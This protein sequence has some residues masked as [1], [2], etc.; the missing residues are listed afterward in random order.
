MTLK[1]A[2]IDFQLR[3]ISLK[4]KPASMLHAS[5]KGTVPVLVLGTQVLEQSLDIM[6]W[7]LSQS[8][9]SGWLSVD[10]TLARA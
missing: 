8:D 10:Q 1:Y 2:G 9:P 4:D 7:A 5:P 6:H 3:E